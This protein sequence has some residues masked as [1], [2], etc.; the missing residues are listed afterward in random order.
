[1]LHSVEEPPTSVHHLCRPKYSIGLTGRMNSAIV[2]GTSL[3]MVVRKKQHNASPV[4]RNKYTL[5]L[6]MI[7]D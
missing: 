3:D 1:M 4:R 7:Y 2:K 6:T 5:K